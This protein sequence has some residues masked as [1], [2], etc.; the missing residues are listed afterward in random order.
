[1][2]TMKPSVA[3]HRQNI[4]F[5]CRREVVTNKG[6]ILY[7]GIDLHLL[8]NGAYLPLF[9]AASLSSCMV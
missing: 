7:Y 4:L 6:K 2:Y 9:S 3:V 1:M 8:V 5:F